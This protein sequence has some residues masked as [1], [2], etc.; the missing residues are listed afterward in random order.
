MTDTRMTIV[1]YT[2]MQQAPAQNPFDAATRAL[3]AAG[4]TV[5][6]A[7]DIPG[8]YSIDGGPELTAHQVADVAWRLEELSIHKDDPRRR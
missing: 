3:S 2:N 6:P 1:D 8:L 5:A 4:H 7:G